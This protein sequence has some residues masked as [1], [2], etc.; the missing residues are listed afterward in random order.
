MQDWTD[1]FWKSIGGDWDSKP[2]SHSPARLCEAPKLDREHEIPEWTSGRSHI[3]S[4]PLASCA[5]LWASDIAPRRVHVLS[6]KKRMVVQ[7]KPIARRVRNNA[8]QVVSALS[9]REST[10]TTGNCC[11]CYK[12]ATSEQPHTL[13][14]RLP[15]WQKCQPWLMLQWKRKPVLQQHIGSTHESPFVWYTYNW[16]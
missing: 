12:K 9:S 4:T 11:L 6:Q 15:E 13:F 16:H 3:A 7:P 2:A 1:A 5:C 8:F 10:C 14:E